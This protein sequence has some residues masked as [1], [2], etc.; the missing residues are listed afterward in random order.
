MRKPVWT[1]EKLKVG[2]DTFLAEHGRL[3]K[4]SE[5]DQVPYL[6]TSRAIQKRFGGLP[7]LR[8]RLGYEDT[9]FAIGEHRS[10]IAY[11][12]GPRGRQLEIELELEL[13][14]RF[15]ER[16]V[17]TEK[18][19]YG[20]QRV[21]FYVY[22]LS[23]QFGVDVFFPATIRSMQNNVNIKMKKYQHFTKPLYLVVANPELTQPELDA[24]AT[25]KVKSF[26]EAVSLLTLTSFRKQIEQYKPYLD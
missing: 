24:Y 20:K 6:P 3:P 13:Q 8:E 18:V 25:N 7:A 1:D 16:S 22:T 17:H 11:E 2:F 19:F 4:A 12:V 21:D 26:S 14:E 23:G 15:G 10:Q 9:N 5:I